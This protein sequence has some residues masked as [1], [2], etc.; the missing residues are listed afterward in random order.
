MNVRPITGCVPN[1]AKK[2]Q[3]TAAPLRRT[4]S[5]V[6]LRMKPALGLRAAT[7]V[8]ERSC[9]R[10]SR[11]LAGATWIKVSFGAI[12]SQSMTSLSGAA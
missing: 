5:P 12:R 2:S 6:P 4:V 10:Q 11:K 9:S 3:D 7:V 8:T 1:I